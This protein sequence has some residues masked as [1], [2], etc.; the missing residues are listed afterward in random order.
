MLVSTEALEVV[1]HPDVGG[2][3]LSSALCDG[4]HHYAYGGDCSNHVAFVVLVGAP[5]L[6]RRRE[7]RGDFALAAVGHG[8][9]RAL[10]TTLEGLLSTREGWH[11]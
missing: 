10:G 5:P 6:M 1:E 9:W 11:G 3:L 2:A 7:P 4:T 8:L